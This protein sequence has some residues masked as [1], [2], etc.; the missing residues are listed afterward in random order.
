MILKT[1]PASIR[2]SSKLSLVQSINWGLVYIQHPHHLISLSVQM[3]DFLPVTLQWLCRCQKSSCRNKYIL[4]GKLWI[5]LAFY[6]STSIAFNPAILF[7]WIW[8][9][10]TWCKAK[11]KQLYLGFIFNWM[12]IAWAGPVKWKLSDQHWSPAVLLLLHWCWQT[13][14]WT[15]ESKSRK[16]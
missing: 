8:R 3:I 12:D 2:L 16:C 11:W 5:D 14:D 7:G 13:T 1:I 15:A 10:W 6:K 4:C 9:I